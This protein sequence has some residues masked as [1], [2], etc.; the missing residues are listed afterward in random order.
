MKL[1]LQN[2]QYFYSLMLNYCGDDFLGKIKNNRR[3]RNYN[4][5]VFL[6]FDI[7]LLWR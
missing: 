1:Q 4:C 5:K 7:K 3:K 2:S 6:F